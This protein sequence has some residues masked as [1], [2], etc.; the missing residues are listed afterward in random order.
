MSG[1]ALTGVIPALPHDSRLVNLSLSH[2]RLKG[3]IPE[4]F[5]PHFKFGV[6][7]LS[8]NKVYY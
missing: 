3:T 2:N 6:M 4:S 8:F 7:D 1:N 5:G